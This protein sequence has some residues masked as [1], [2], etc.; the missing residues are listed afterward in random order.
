MAPPGALSIMMSIFSMF[1]SA[2]DGFQSAVPGSS[3]SGKSAM[4]TWKAIIGTCTPP[5]EATVSNTVRPVRSK[6]P[7]TKAMFVG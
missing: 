4:P 1:R 5:T 3:G 7:G 6:P 2:Y